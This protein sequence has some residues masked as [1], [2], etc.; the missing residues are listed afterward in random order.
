MP[1]NTAKGVSSNT[2]GIKVQQS[3]QQFSAPSLNSDLVELNQKETLLKYQALYSL[4]VTPARVEW[5]EY[6]LHCYKQS[7]KS[8]LVDGFCVK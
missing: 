7:T 5:L 4:T 6:L 3:T 8:F 2:F 1:E